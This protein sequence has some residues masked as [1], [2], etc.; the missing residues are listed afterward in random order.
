MNKKLFFSKL[1]ENIKN[2]IY[3]NIKRSN[4]EKI[5]YNEFKKNIKKKWL[6]FKDYLL[7]KLF[8]I[9]YKKNNKG[10]K[11]IDTKDIEKRPYVSI[12]LNKFPYKFPKNI[13]HYILW[14][15]N[16]KIN[17][18]EIISFVKKKGIDYIWWENP[19]YKKSVKEIPHIHILILNN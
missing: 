6:T 1:K 2:G 5:K 12:I 16:E 17:K 7:N 13:D 11:Y 9:Q 14:K 15:I 18:D 8:R 3:T 10:I 19:Y 4:E